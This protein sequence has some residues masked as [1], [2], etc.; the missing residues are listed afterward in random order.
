M[1]T[2]IL[3]VMWKELREIL[4][5]DGRFQ[6]GAKNILILLGIAGVL[7][8][9]QAGPQWF[10]SWLSV[11]SACFPI[12]LVLN[13]TADAFAGERERH[14]LE[15]LLASR[16]DD[17]AILLGKLAAIVVY[18]WGLV[19][20]C[21]PLAVV[22]VNLANRGHGLLFFRPEILLAIAGVSLAAALVICSVGVL[23]SLTAPTVRAAG[24][25]M[26][27]PFFA[28]FALPMMLPWLARKAHWEGALTQLTP[29]MAVAIVAA[30]FFAVAAAAIALALRRFTRER[31]VL[32]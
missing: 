9:I 6:G 31:L 7:F 21:Q 4:F 11:S 12:I 15:T 22:A 16:L 13:Y 32:A 29:P 3:V 19:L 25:R 17:R 20:V 27:V 1:L 30:V 23:V 28:V 18:G 14:T 5:P 24:Q 2:D 8:P 26:L 10:S